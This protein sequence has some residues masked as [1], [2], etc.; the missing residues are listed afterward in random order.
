[1]PGWADN[2]WK[3]NGW[4]GEGWEASGGVGPTPP[5]PSGDGAHWE[6]WGGAWESQ[7]GTHWEDVHE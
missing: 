2:S 7:D 5:A 3:V 1:M 6:D 4:E